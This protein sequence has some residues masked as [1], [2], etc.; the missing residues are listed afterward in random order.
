MWLVTCMNTGDPVG[1]ARRLLAAGKAE[2]R[3]RWLRV[4]CASMADVFEDHPALP[5]ERDRLWDL[6]KKTPAIDGQLLTKRPENV[7]DMAPWGA[8]WPANVW[9]GVSVEA[10]NE[11]P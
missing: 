5:P 3:G 10:T 4:F 9:L 6:I 11:P 7:A 2:S 1:R 8:S